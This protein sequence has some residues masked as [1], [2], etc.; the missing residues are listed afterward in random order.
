MLLA[1]S[2]LLLV[3]SC[4]TLRSEVFTYDLATK[5]S[6]YTK[7]LYLRILSSKGLRL[8]SPNG[9]DVSELS[10]ITWDADENILYAVSDEG[11]LYHLGIKIYNK[12]IVEVNVLKEFLLKNRN[13]KALKKKW[14]DSEGLSSNNDNNGIKGDTELIVSFEGKP[15]VIRYTPEGVYIDDV[16]LPDKLTHKKKYRHKNKALESVTF[17]P[18][19]GLITAAEFPM[20]SKQETTQTLYTA[21][22]KEWNFRA[23]SA[24]KSAVTGLEVLPNGNILVLE[25]AWAGIQNPVV[26]NLSEINIRNCK[27]STQCVLKNL[28]SLSSSEGWLLD[29]FE[30]LAHFRENLYFMISDNN[31]NIFQTTV[32]VLFEVKAKRG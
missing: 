1:V 9:H 4:T 8:K 6:Y 20:K 23:S 26:I 11:V 17:H 2:C 3:V 15:R 19:E 24:K 28:A 29:N 32:L 22:G 25:R 27:P 14:R 21:T 18:K 7:P 16:T 12:S 13:H 10:G 31:E 5:Q 30:G